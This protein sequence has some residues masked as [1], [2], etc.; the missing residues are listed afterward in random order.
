MRRLLEGVRR[1]LGPTPRKLAGLP[2]PTPPAGMDCVHPLWRA[3]EALSFLTR[4]SEVLMA[5]V[6]TAH[7]CLYS[8]GE[9]AAFARAIFPSVSDGDYYDLDDLHRAAVEI[10]QLLTGALPVDKKLCDFASQLRVTQAQVGK[11]DV[12]RA[13]ARFQKLQLSCLVVYPSLLP[14]PYL[15]SVFLPVLVHPDIEPIAMVPARFWGEELTRAWIEL[16]L[17]LP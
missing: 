16:S 17:E 5:V 8:P 2:H 15:A 1:N 14:R 7:E 11:V 10:E 9:N 3:H 12:P 4:D 13:I 6:I